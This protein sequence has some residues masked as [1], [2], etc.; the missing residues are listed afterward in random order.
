MLKIL[1]IE[2]S[3]FLGGVQ[4]S[5]INFLKEAIHD[6]EIQ[7]V[8][9]IAGEGPLVEICKELSVE[10]YIYRI[11]KP[12]S[13]S[14]LIT[15][16][17][18]RIPNPIA[19]LKHLKDIRK[20][21][22]NLLQLIH[23]QKINFDLIITKG[24]I[25]HV[26]G[27]Q[28]ARAKS[29]PVIW[30]VQDY[31]TARYWG[32]YRKL[33][34]YLSG[35]YA[36]LVIADGWPIVEVLGKK[37]KEKAEVIY[38]GVDT[39]SFYKPDKKL[40]LKI[41]LGFSHED[42]IIGHVARIVPTKGQMTLVKAFRQVVLKYPQARLLLIGSPLFGSE[43]YFLRIK[44]YIQDHQLGDKVLMPGYVNDLTNAYAAMDIF[45][46]PVEEKDTCPLSIL[47]ALAAGA[48]IIASRID[49]IYEVIKDAEDVYFYEKENDKV[50]ALL[51]SELIERGN[52]PEKAAKNHQYAKEYFDNTIFYQN[53]KRT[54]QKIL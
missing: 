22:N 3:A 23:Q 45:V 13:T 49:G 51:I 18:I 39:A 28:V 50:L 43:D 26:P 12:I 32:L 9:L 25:S 29:R 27:A 54:M 37:A 2:D 5:T 53:I 48:P 8:V 42:F 38:N 4:H 46:Y 31:V 41:Q 7:P 6:P 30:H 34:G 20:I 11:P 35:R 40:N 16:T 52:Y 47:G 10:H 44:Q 24:M 1:I 15:G 33:F 14:I 19:L 21:R 17:S 36:D